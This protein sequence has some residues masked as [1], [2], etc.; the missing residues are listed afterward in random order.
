MKNTRKD[1]AVASDISTDR[2]KN[3]ASD[4]SIDKLKNVASL[5]DLN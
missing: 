2:L 4:I 3:V 1:V 5:R